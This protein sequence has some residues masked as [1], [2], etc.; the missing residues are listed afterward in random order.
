MQVFRK[1]I[2]DLPLQVMTHLELEVSGEQREEKIAGSLLGDFIPLQLQCTLPA[3]LE[4][5]GQ[6]VVQARAGRWTCD[7]LARSSKELTQ[8]TLPKDT[9]EPEIWVF[10]ARPELRVVEIE[11]L[12]TIDASQTLLPDDWRNLPAYKISPELAMSFKVIRRGDPEP[13]PNQLNLT[14]KLWLDFDGSG[15]TVNDIIT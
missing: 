6:L 4:P 1:V 3:R 8:L 7:I 15:Y 11:S 12:S 9:L 2:D 13:E 14:R 5:N 10:D